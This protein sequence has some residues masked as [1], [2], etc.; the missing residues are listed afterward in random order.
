MTTKATSDKIKELVTSYQK[1]AEMKSPA[2]GTEV[3]VEDYEEVKSMWLKHYRSAPVPVTE[4]I[5]SRED[6]L[7]VEQ[8]K[9]T[10]ITNL[11]SSSNPQLKQQGLE[12]V[13]EILPFLLLGGFSE[14]EIM[15]YVKAK[16]EADRQVTEELELEEKAKE[17]AKEE[18]KEEE[19]L[20]DVGEKKVEEGEK[21]EVLKQEI[22]I[23]EEKGR[24]P[25]RS[26][27]TGTATGA[28]GGSGQE[29]KKPS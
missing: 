20:I 1:E 29:G 26:A 13:S 28:P 19:E 17:K 21:A 14:P 4:T 9:L 23:G 11:L 15:T 16:L 27:E 22:K 24:K 25:D 6:W 10:N 5:K 7:N 12:K 3:S 2:L 18:L 8:K